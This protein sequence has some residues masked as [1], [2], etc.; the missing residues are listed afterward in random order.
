ML[1]AHGNAGDSIY[2]KGKKHFL[3]VFENTKVEFVTNDPDVL[4]FL[5][6]NSSLNAVEQIQKNVFRH[7]LMMASASDNAYSSAI[8][9]KAWMNQ[10]GVSSTLLEYDS[11]ETSRQ[12]SYLYD[13]KNAFARM[14]KKRI[15]VPQEQMKERVASN[16]NPFLLES[17][18]GI[19]LGYKTVENPEEIDS[20]LCYGDVCSMV[21]MLLVNEVCKQLPRVAE[22]VKLTAPT[23]TFE[24][25]EASSILADCCGLKAN[26]LDTL[27]G[28]DEFTLFRFD[29]TLTKAFATLATLKKRSANGFALEL[30]LTPSALSYFTENP[31]GNHHL[32]LS[33]NHVQKLELACMLKKI[34]AIA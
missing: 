1:L 20:D 4:V 31:L 7:Y 27:Q 30:K 22:V 32:I 5:S 15:Y 10:H 9:V 12:I 24:S 29:N 16:I 25:C 6:K 18:F 19:Q 26:N 34:A 14:N 23:I 17:R 33:G 21:G 8:E 13:I 3:D 28:T 2:N 11:P